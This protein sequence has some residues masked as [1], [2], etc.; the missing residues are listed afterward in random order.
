MIWILKMYKIDILSGIVVHNS[1]YSWRG[2]DFKNILNFETDYPNATV[3]K[4]EQ[5]YRSTETILEAAHAVDVPKIHYVLTKSYG[6]RKARGRR[7]MFY[8]YSTKELKLKQ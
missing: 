4:L 8:N 5:N 6:R 7:F 1:I 2:A 3:I